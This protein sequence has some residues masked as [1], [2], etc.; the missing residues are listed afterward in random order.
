MSDNVQAQVLAS[1]VSYFSV[2]TPV[3][4]LGN[5]RKDA[6]GNPVQMERR[7]EAYHG[8]TI[9]L[10]PY[11][12]ARLQELGA[13]REPSSEPL[14]GPQVATPFGVP[15]VDAS[16]GQHV[17]FKGPVMG[18]PRPAGPDVDNLEFTRDGRPGGLSPEEA[19]RLEAVARGEVDM[20]GDEVDYTTSEAE[21]A[22]SGAS[23][24]SVDIIDDPALRLGD[25]PRPEGNS[26]GES[27]D[28]YESMKKAELEALADERGLEIEGSGANGNVTKDDLV[29]ALE[30]A[31]EKGA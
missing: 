19:A 12:F 5:P 3:D 24:A 23:R 28:G 22:G 2:H 1:G 18:D 20:N 7:H 29:A 31:D 6:Q 25:T 4:P 21:Q 9:S 10:S 27:G 30:D 26:L 13:V 15:I 16:T 17:A 14:R 8:E 11:E